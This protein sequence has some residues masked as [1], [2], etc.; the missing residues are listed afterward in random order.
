VGA[1]ELRI[2]GRDEEGSAAVRLLVEEF[3]VEGAAVRPAIDGGIRH[4]ILLPSFIKYQNYQIIEKGKV[5]KWVGG[6]N[7]LE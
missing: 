1:L 2:G 5:I 4:R 3:A 6:H 7:Y